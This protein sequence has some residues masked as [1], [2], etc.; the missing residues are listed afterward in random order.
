MAITE[1]IF[2]DKIFTGGLTSLCKSVSKELNFRDTNGVGSRWDD[3]FYDIDIEELQHLELYLEEKISA[4][5]N[6][7]K[8]KNMSRNID[9]A[10]KRTIY[11]ISAMAA[12]EI[13]DGTQKFGVGNYWVNDKYNIFVTNDTDYREDDDGNDIITTYYVL[14]L[15][16]YD[17]ND[18][19]IDAEVD[20]ADTISSDKEELRMAVEEMITFNS[21]I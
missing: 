17:E 12:D 2:N 20:Y 7:I 4:K 13:Y 3:N 19:C 5:F 10:T 15:E 16:E 6:Q 21:L 9:K 8:E 11:D 14:H 1:I 18:N